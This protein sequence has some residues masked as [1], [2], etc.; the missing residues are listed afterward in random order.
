M[1]VVA[2]II[3][4][5]GVNVPYEDEW[6]FFAFLEKWESNGLT[7]ADFYSAHNGHRIVIPRLIYLAVIQL[8]NG[9][10]RA[11]M[12]FSLFL[13]ILTSAGIYLLLRRTVSGSTTKHLALWALMNL[14]LFSPIQAENWLWGFQLQ[15]FL[16]NL[17]IVGAIVCVTSE[18]G[19]LVRL[20]TAL[21]FALAGTFSFGNGL[22]IWP[23]LFVVLFCRREKVTVQVAWIT[24]G[25]LVLLAYLPGYPAREPVPPTTQWFD[26]LLYFA[27]FLGAPLARIPNSNPLVLPVIVGSILLTGYLWNAA[28]LVRHRETLRNTAPWLALGAYVIA[29]AAMASVAR[30]HSGPFHALDSRYTT[31]SVVLVVSLI[32]LVAAAIH[33]GGAE[34]ASKSRGRSVIAGMAIGGLLILYVINIPFELRYLRLN[35]SF[36]ARG[37]GA[38]EFSSVLELNQ[39]VRSTLL[40]RE[41]PDALTRYLGMLDRLEL[42]DP[43]RRKTLVLSDAEDRPKRS[44]NEYGVFEALEVESPGILVASGWSYLPAEGRPPAGV[45]LAYRSGHEWKAFAFSG[46]TEPRP[47]LVIKHESRSYLERGWRQ[48]LAWAILP[49]GGQEISAWALEANRGATYRLP[50]AFQLQR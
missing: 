12:F 38:L 15:V 47:D 37:K 29:S 11:E 14:F 18:T 22:L 33:Q 16:S 17:C 5:Y 20:G 7:F 23:C 25:V 35:H 28:R 26:Y 2:A 39:M 27:G 3:N 31:V 4:R 13:C 30:V 6:K 44:T 48:S 32:G 46:V 19:L 21:I 9:N 49:D 50:G 34:A 1:M 45:V 8:I 24:A 10:L 43:P 41:D 36:R 42:I 40:I